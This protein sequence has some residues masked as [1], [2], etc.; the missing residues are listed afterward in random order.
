MK[1]IKDYEKAYEE[2]F[3]RNEDRKQAY[4]EW[5]SLPDGDMIYIETNGE[6]VGYTPKSLIVTRK[7]HGVNLEEELTNLVNAYKE[8][9]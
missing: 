6:R 7:I 5:E 2:I 4:K 9:K 1:T 3:A 8:N